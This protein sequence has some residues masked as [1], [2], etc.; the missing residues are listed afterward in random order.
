MSNPLQLEG[1]QRIWDHA[2]H[3]A[4]PDLQWWKGNLYCALREGDAHE[5]GR[6]GTIALLQRQDESSWLL[7]DRLPY[8]QRDLRDPKLSIAPDGSLHLLAGAAKRDSAGNYL[9]F[10]SVARRLTPDYQWTDWQPIGEE[11][12]WLWRLSWQ[13]EE[14]YGIAYSIPNPAHRTTP[15]QAALWHTSDGTNYRTISNLEV[16]SYPSE[17]TIVVSTDNT[18]T[19]VLRRGMHEE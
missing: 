8:P 10:D 12:W 19:A 1:L 17:G 9:R 7:I 3:N 14:G 15:W 13:K 16:G 11:A 5:S 2:P 4:F 18:M 6:N